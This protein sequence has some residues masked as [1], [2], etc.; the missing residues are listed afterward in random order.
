MIDMVGPIP[1]GVGATLDDIS[2]QAM[3]SELVKQHP[4]VASASVS[5]SM[6]LA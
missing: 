3:T 6:R 2:K 4:S 5:A 1:Y